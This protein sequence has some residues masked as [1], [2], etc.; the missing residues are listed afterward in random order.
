M[1][2]SDQEKYMDLALQLKWHYVFNQIYS[3]IEN[4]LLF[5]SEFINV[6]QNSTLF[7][8]LLKEINDDEKA[9]ALCIANI[10]MLS[11]Y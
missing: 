3:N 11:T 10:I 7:I 5:E 6:I 2:S 9:Y 1:D 8:K 4:I